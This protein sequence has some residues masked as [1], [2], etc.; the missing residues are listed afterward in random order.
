MEDYIPKVGDKV[1]I[2]KSSKCWNQAGHMDKHVGKI[3]TIGAIYDDGC[4]LRVEFKEQSED[5][6][7]KQWIWSYRHD[8]F[9]PFA[10]HDKKKLKVKLKF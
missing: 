6:E 10:P 1:I 3:V 4:S 9:K 7:L 5:I 2:T 8:H